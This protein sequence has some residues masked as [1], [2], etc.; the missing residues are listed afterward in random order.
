MA[1]QSARSTVTGVNEFQSVKYTR[2]KRKTIR[3]VQ[4]NPQ[5]IFYDNTQKEREGPESVT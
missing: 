3:H 1:W 4:K 5:I 2:P